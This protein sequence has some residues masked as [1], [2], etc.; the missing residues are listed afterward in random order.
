VPPQYLP[1]C[2]VPARFGKYCKVMP[3][4]GFLKLAD[5]S[6]GLRAQLEAQLAEYMAEMGPGGAKMPTSIRGSGSSRPGGS[7]PS[8]RM[9]ASNDAYADRDTLVATAVA[10]RSL[11]GRRVEHE[12]TVQLAAR[13]LVDYPYGRTRLARGG[14]DDDGGDDGEAPVGLRYLRRLSAEAEV[15][16]T[17]STTTSAVEGEGDPYAA[18]YGPLVARASSSARRLVAKHGASAAAR[19]LPGFPYTPEDEARASAAIQE[20]VAEVG[21]A[22]TDG[23]IAGTTKLASYFQRILSIQ[24]TIIVV[25]VPVTL[26]AS[27]DGIA[28][29]DLGV[30]FCIDRREFTLTVVPSMNFQA[31][32]SVAINLA[33]VSG[34]LTIA[35]NL[36]TTALIPT[37]SFGLDTGGGFRAALQMTLAMRPFS[38][39]VSAGVRFF[40]FDFIK[41]KVCLKWIKLA[42]IRIPIPWFCPRTSIVLFRLKG[43]L[44]KLLLFKVATGPYDVTPPKKGSVTLRQA[45]EDRLVVEH[46]GFVDGDSDIDHYTVCVGSAPGKCEVVPTTNVFND[47]SASF[48]GMAAKLANAQ[49]LFATVVAYNGE[50][51][52]TS[53]STTTVF[54][55]DA[56]A[57]LATDI[58]VRRTLDGVW[59]T[60]SCAIPGQPDPWCT[61]QARPIVVNDSTALA[62]R[63]FVSEPVPTVNITLI[64]W[65]I[66]TAPGGANV[67]GWTDVGRAAQMEAKSADPY[68]VTMDDVPEGALEH[69][70]TYYFSVHTVNSRSLEAVFSSPGFFLDTTPPNV[71]HVW[72]YYDRPAPFWRFPQ[73]LMPGWAF[74]DAEA[75]RSAIVRYAWSLRDEASGSLLVDAEDTGDVNSAIWAGPGLLSHSTRYCVDVAATNLGGATSEP[76]SGCTVIDLVDPEFNWDGPVWRDPTQPGDG[77]LLGVAVAMAT[78][79]LDR[80]LS[81]NRTDAFTPELAASVIDQ[82]GGVEYTRAGNAS[83]PGVP[84]GFVFESLWDEYRSPEEVL[85]LLNASTPSLGLPPLYAN[86]QDIAGTGHQVLRLRWAVGD[87]VSRV[88]DCTV[89]VGYFRGD[90][91]VMAPKPVPPATHVYDA[92]DPAGANSSVWAP[93]AAPGVYS[94][95]ASGFG[96]YEGLVRYSATGYG[97]VAVYPTVECGDAA[98]NR[99]KRFSV[100]GAVVDQTPPTVVNAELLRQ[101]WHQDDLING[102]LFQNE[103]SLFNVSWGSPHIAAFFELESGVVRVCAWLGTA[104]NATNIAAPR[105]LDGVPVDEVPPWLAWANLTMPHST[106]VHATLAVSNY[107]T[108]P[109]VKFVQ[110]PVPTLV[111]LTPPVVDGVGDGHPDM[112]TLAWEFSAPLPGAP[113]VGDINFTSYRDALF[114]NWAGGDPESGIAEWRLAVEDA[115]TGQLVGAWRAMYDTKGFLLTDAPLAHNVT[116]RA[117]LVAVNRAG[118]A[119]NATLSD[120][121]TVDLTPPVV[122]EPAWPGGSYYASLNTSADVA[123]FVGAETLPAGTQ[124]PVLSST[125]PFVALSWAVDEDVSDIVGCGVML[126]TFPSGDDLLPLTPQPGTGSVGTHAFNASAAGLGLNSGNLVFATVACLNYAGALGHAFSGALAVDTLPPFV[127]PVLPVLSLADPVQVAFTGSSTTAVAVWPYMG[128]AHSAPATCDVALGPN[129]GS[130]ANRTAYLP[131]TPTG[132]ALSVVATGLALPPGPA[133]WSLRCTDRVGNAAP[134]AESAPFVVDLTP[135]YVPLGGPLPPVADGGLGGV[136]PDGTLD[137]AVPDADFWISP[138]D[139]VCRCPAR[140]DESGLADIVFALSTAPDGSPPFLAGPLPTRGFPAALFTGLS[141]PTN[142]TVYCVATATNAVNQSV[143]WVSDGAFVDTTPPQGGVVLIT[144]TDDG[145]YGLPWSALLPRA[146]SASR[147]DRGLLVSYRGWDPESGIVDAYLTVGYTVGGGEVLPAMPVNLSALEAYDTDEDGVPVGRMYLF[148]ST[149]D[150]GNAPW[151]DRQLYV[152]LSLTNGAG[153]RAALAGG[154]VVFDSTPPSPPSS[155]PYVDVAVLDGPDGFTNLPMTATRNATHYNCTFHI[156]DPESGPL[157]TYRAGVGVWTGRPE[158]VWVPLAGNDLNGGYEMMYSL[159]PSLTDGFVVDVINDGGYDATHPVTVTFPLPDLSSWTDPAYNPTGLVTLFGVV[160]AVN[161]LGMEARYRSRGVLLDAA[162]P[163]CAVLWDVPTRRQ[164]Q[165]L[166]FWDD[167]TASPTFLLDGLGDTGDATLDYRGDAWATPYAGALAGRG[168]SC[169]DAGSGMHHYELGAQVYDKAAVAAAAAAAGTATAPAV[170]AEACPDVD[171][172]NATEGATSGC[173]IENGGVYRLRLTAIDAV[174][175]R[176]V[177]YSDGQLVDYTPPTVSAVVLD[178]PPTAGVLG[179]TS[180]VHFTVAVGDPESGL[181]Q[182]TYAVVRF[183]DT[184]APV[185][186]LTFGDPDTGAFSGGVTA[187][188]LALNPGDRYRVV[189]TAVNRLGAVTTALSEPFL[190]DDSPPF[191]GDSLVRAVALPPSVQSQPGYP[192]LVT[193]ANVSVSL[194]GWVDIESGVA[195]LETMLV[196]TRAASA[197][198]VAVA[199]AAALAAPDPPPLVDTPAGVAAWCAAVGP[200]GNG[201]VVRL[202]PIVSL[203][204]LG[205]V[206]KL[207]TGLALCNESWLVPVAAA[208]NPLQQYTVGAGTPYRYFVSRLT[209]GTVWDG[210]TPGA[211]LAALPVGNGA[212]VTWSPWVDSLGAEVTYEAA[213]SA[214]APGGTELSGGWLRAKGEAPNNASIVDRFALAD[215]TRVWATVRGSVAGGASIAATTD[216]VLYD[217]TP[218]ALSGVVIGSAAFQHEVALVPGAP[219]SVAWACADPHS[220]VVSVEVSVGSSAAAPDSLVRALVL[221]GTLARVG[222]AVVPGLAP[223]QGASLLARVV[224]TNGVGASTTSLSPLAYAD[225]TPPEARPVG[226]DGT[227]LGVSASWPPGGGYSPSTQYANSS[228]ILYARWDV[229]DTDGSGVAGHVVCVGTRLTLDDVLP[230]TPVGQASALALLLNPAAAACP[231]PVAPSDGTGAAGVAIACRTAV[232]AAAAALAGGDTLYVRLRSRNWANLTTALSQRV[233][234]ELAPPDVAASRLSV[235]VARRLPDAGA[236]DRLLLS[237]TDGSPGAAYADRA[238]AVDVLLTGLPAAPVSPL[239]T[240]TLTVSAAPNATYA[241]VV[242]PPVTLALARLERA[243]DV[244]GGYVASLYTPTGVSLSRGMTYAVTCVVTSAA[245]NAAPPLVALF[246]PDAD[247]PSLSGVAISGVPAAA[248]ASSSSESGEG[249]AWPRTDVLTVVWDAADG[250]SGVATTEARVCDAEVSLAACTEPWLTLPAN[251]SAPRAPNA[252]S[253]A[254]ALASDLTG[255]YTFTGLALQPGRSYAVGVRVTDFAGHAAAAVSAP[256]LVDPRPPMAARWVAPVGYIARPGDTTFVFTPFVSPTTPIVRVQL[257]LGASSDPGLALPLL[258]WTTVPPALLVPGYATLS[259]APT[260]VRTLRLADLLAPGADGSPPVYDMEVLLAVMALAGNVTGYLRATNGAGLTTVVT[261]PGPLLFDVTPPELDANFS[262][263]RVGFVLAARGVAGSP[264]TL[265]GPLFFL[266][267]KVAALPASSA[268][269]APN[270]ATAPTSLAATITNTTAANATGNVSVSVGAVNATAGAGASAAGGAAGAGFACGPTST[271]GGGWVATLGQ[272]DLAALTVGWAGIVDPSS[273]I[274]TTAQLSVAACPP[275]AP[276]DSPACLVVAADVAVPFYAGAYTL[277]GLA[278]V[279]NGTFTATLTVTNGAGAARVFATAQALLI[280][281]DAPELPAVADGWAPGSPVP[282]GWPAPAVASAIGGANDTDYWLAADLVAGSWSSYDPSGIAEFRW[283]VCRADANSVTAAASADCPLPWTSAGTA[284]SARAVL[285]LG[286]WLAQGGAYRTWVAAIDSAGNVA[287]AQSDGFVVDTTRPVATGAQVVAPAFAASWRDVR[288]ALYNVTDDESAIADVAV[289]VTIAGAGA[290]PSTQLLPCTRVPL[291][292]VDTPTLAE[293]VGN[294]TLVAAADAAITAALVQ[295]AVLDAGTPD[296]ARPLPL[297]LALDAVVTNRA[298]LSVR[299]SAGGV[300]L[301]ALPAGVMSI[302]VVPGDAWDGAR[303]NGSATP[304]REALAKMARFSRNTTALGFAWDLLPPQSGIAALSAG[305]TTD[306]AGGA[307]AAVTQ[308]RSLPPGAT[309]VAFT[310]LDLA[311]GRV[312]FLSLNVTTGAGVMTAFCGGTADGAAGFDPAA[313]S[314]VV[315]MTPPS[316]GVVVDVLSTANATDSPAAS[317]GVLYR[318][319]SVAAA[320]WSGFADE[321]SGVARYDVRVCEADGAVCVTEWTDVGAA[322]SATLSVGLRPGVTYRVHVR[323]YDGAGNR[324]TALSPGQVYVNTPPVPPQRLV[325]DRFVI[326]HWANVSLDWDDFVSPQAG[327]ARYEVALEVEV[328]ASTTANVNGTRATLLPRTPVGTDTRYKLAGAQLA[329]VE[330]AWVALNVSTRPARWFASVLAVDKAGLVSPSRSAPGLLDDT[331]PT[332]GAVAFVSVDALPSRSYAITAIVSQTTTASTNASATE[333]EGET[334]GPRLETLVVRQD[335]LAAPPRYQLSRRAL[336]FTWTGFRDAEQALLA[337][338]EPLTYVYGVG[339]AAGTDDVVRWTRWF[340]PPLLTL[341]GSVAGGTGGDMDFGLLPSSDDSTVHSVTVSSLDLPNGAT[342]VVT[343]RAINAAG[344]EAASSSAALVIDA[345]APRST[346]AR[347]VIDLQARV[348]EDDVFFNTTLLD[349]NTTD[350]NATAPTVRGGYGGVRTDLPDYDATPISAWDDAD[351]TGSEIALSYA[352]RGFDDPQSGLDHVEY[353]VVQLRADDGYAAEVLDPVADGRSRAQAASTSALTLSASYAAYVAASGGV[354]R[355]LR[356]SA[357]GRRRLQTPDELS[358]G[359]DTYDPEANYTEDVEL[360]TSFGTVGPRNA[361]A[362]LPEVLFVATADIV[363]DAPVQPAYAGRLASPFVYWGG[364]PQTPWA[365]YVPPEGEPPAEGVPP[366]PADVGTGNVTVSGLQLVPGG[367]YALAVRAYSRSSQFTQ[368]LSDGA[369]YDNGVPC[370]GRISVG[371]RTAR[372]DPPVVAA[373]LAG[374]LGSAARPSAELVYDDASRA[375]LLGTASGDAV[376]GVYYLPSADTLTLSFAHFADPWVQRPSALQRL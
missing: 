167:G 125:T 184:P 376:D 371:P 163:V 375:S 242:I 227:L 292:L 299:F 134:L 318:S 341:N 350:P 49:P 353:S 144:Q 58:R 374:T 237:S 52:P 337:S 159:F 8:Y 305:L 178:P 347:P 289:C 247:T 279:P 233:V 85:P 328:E 264:A 365:E 334:N 336:S 231:A 142:T 98:G 260:P 177:V 141:L 91:S 358:S 241:E 206:G 12:S 325:V 129:A 86:G 373:V 3:G 243:P 240:V 345:D 140:D 219:V 275:D 182:W 2:I 266:R 48:S 131:W 235:V 25:V 258:N 188:G 329:A 50:L 123:R 137:P 133:V 15:D 118:S 71:S 296:A 202:T 16:V 310:S 300:K 31:M 172:G 57:P 33:I 245:G 355:R 60:Q 217:S 273:G 189:V 87:N 360:V 304:S 270:N 93:G 126:G 44:L 303:F 176:T 54:Y 326:S 295:Q 23:C 132:A 301:D 21:Q 36:L 143:T 349:V 17:I 351:W 276:V 274:A 155:W 70:G 4:M 164:R 29:L 151:T 30:S 209:P 317:P 216:G 160:R 96:Y 283:A 265:P 331:P 66:G 228:S 313:W 282:L 225:G 156:V 69:G 211:D 180:S 357:R 370:F 327:V 288:F 102:R 223:P 73:L 338:R 229:V 32:A 110:L 262:A 194:T 367:M 169:S 309:A 175:L 249:T 62:F 298:G 226:G 27:L 212:W 63:W 173:V 41:R 323:G 146:T 55:W 153:G 187:I 20:L 108:P 361:S 183:G 109:G 359:L 154:P 124:L 252:S 120:G 210:W 89:C 312:Y 204:P 311:P 46:E 307:D 348:S 113:G 76:F 43:P 81:P 148:T 244:P 103:S 34:D 149:L 255:S 277:T 40:A 259:G 147:A 369:R 363:T 186:G 106:L 101:G 251:A 335:I 26:S 224:C 128:D 321:A 150:G 286:G 364:V 198:D 199:M 5:L 117:R 213:F 314:V 139:F 19:R 47:Q 6:P 168:W 218:P 302:S 192:A 45:T 157:V 80:A 22:P 267:R 356:V 354:A 368:L 37:L 130:D 257:A 344:L 136:L 195:T 53:G 42:F 82:L 179:T 28:R 90:C 254:H 9:L 121:V 324:I 340:E 39:E 119:A 95:V 294:D 162:P 200:G 112:P 201:S 332:P 253:S 291:S 161:T 248:A 287:V 230:C 284:T 222:A 165:L 339:T 68:I 135:P 97:G 100:R 315:D 205:D 330:A 285:P 13:A 196:L 290:R 306:C 88:A 78:E 107:A 193:G 261:S 83:V 181:S 208:S 127:G 72:G 281:T 239:A 269:G 280:D 346:H 11:G 51:M 238:M 203:N 268:P 10:G 67:V 56:A 166:G 190:V 293:A 116:Y 372:R 322:T 94:V 74:S 220:D 271:Q 207:W 105:C 138:T 84:R 114:A 320:S 191:M 64:E 7:A 319:T 170:W 18:V 234:L 343:L 215:G 61:T 174:G 104:P 185:S 250:H 263:D 308:V 38:I 24:S 145:A 65:A 35:A 171:I 158:S 14:D 256:V 77:W 246:R 333:G 99:G 232:P 278:L 152:T 115:S 297:V 272:A 197:A 362:A 1:R 59:S 342:L 79:S 316:A 111:D 236:P 352:W 214:V 75:P 221:N 366:T 92:A 122:S